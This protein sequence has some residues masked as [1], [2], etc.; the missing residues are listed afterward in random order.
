M[1]RT[2]AALL[3]LGLS[4]ATPAGADVK[5][6]S[7]IA[8]HGDPDVFDEAGAA[9]ARSMQHDIH[10]HAGLSCH[11]C[12]GGNP[13]LEIADDMTAAMDEGFT[14]N[15]YRGVP[16][17]AEIP[18][19]CGR[20]HSDPVFMRRFRPTLRVDQVQE[21]WTSDHGRGLRR[22]DTAVATCVDCHG[23]HGMLGVGDSDSPV[24]R[25]RVAETCGRCHQNVELMAGRTLSDGRPLPVDQLAKWQRSVH[26]QALLVRGDLSAPTCNDCHGNHGAVPPG[27][28]SIAFVC[29]Q[30][31]GREAE[32]FRD[33]PKF[34]AFAAH[35]ELLAEAG[36]KAC[37][38]CHPH[39]EPQASVVGIPSFTECAT[40]HGYHGVVAAQVTML[41]PLPAYPC[42][43]CHE[44]VGQVAA[45]EPEPA[46]A[47][48]NY[49]DVRDGLL[50]AA[51][52][53]GLEGAHLFD[54]MLERALEAPHHTLQE[55]AEDGKP[56]PRPEF[57]RLFGKFRLGRTYFTYLDPASGEE[58][59][60]PVRSCAFCHR[61]DGTG[62]EA[63]GLI[64]ARRQAEALHELAGLTARAERIF[65]RARRGG[66]E[67]RQTLGAIDQAVDAQIS[68]QVLVHA[69]DA[70]PGSAFAVQHAEGVARAQEALV[71]GREA[72]EELAARRRGLLLSLLIILAV[73]VAL[74]LKIRQLS[75]AEDRLPSNETMRR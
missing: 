72:L 52:A 48:R 69:F 37:A 13:A 57:A 10:A 42:A 28:E 60:E 4:T 22:G 67:T 65:L 44:P 63:Q 59:R 17:R 50:A 5:P 56:R 15:P 3:V 51:A 40:C 32:L 43:L 39:P 24:Y 71:G 25:T 46:K 54:W 19:F 68:L 61:D 11:D 45:L 75:A 9:L 7:C 35:N 27:V 1:M 70:G 36:V 47:R 29:G 26:A 23:V 2:A 18:D 66:V 30:C 16:A 53:A 58:Q 6:T 31:H 20:C 8:C 34:A 73:L 14:P 62:D 33:S 74:G 12:H 64:T 38:A 41:A 55:P 21:Y 49:E